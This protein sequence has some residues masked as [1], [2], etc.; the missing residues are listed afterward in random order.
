[1]AWIEEPTAGQEDYE[2]LLMVKEEDLECLPPAAVSKAD[3]NY[4]KMRLTYF[5][6][7]KVREFY[8]RIKNFEEF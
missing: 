5:E 8:G 4:L 1:M 3:R 6:K 2:K 7:E